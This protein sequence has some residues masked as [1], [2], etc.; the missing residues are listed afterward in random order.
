[1]GWDYAAP[2]SCKPPRFGSISP[3]DASS[4]CAAA[5]VLEH[6]NVGPELCKGPLLQT[7]P[8]QGSGG[9][10]RHQRVARQRKNGKKESKEPKIR[11]TAE[12]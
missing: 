11:G 5:R 9:G 1:M 10:H 12:K 8:P 3:S 7:C 6:R 2:A 4:P